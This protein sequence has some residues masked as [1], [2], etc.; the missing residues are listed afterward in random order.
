ML[1]RVKFFLVVLLVVFAM[2]CF[3]FNGAELSKAMNDAAYAGEYLNLIMHP[4]MPKPWTN[5]MYSEMTKKL[6]NAWKVIT[7]EVSSIENE[8][9]IESCRA[10]IE[11]FK[12]SH[13]TYRD[14]GFQV[15]ISLNDRIKF[16]QTHGQL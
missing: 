14:L 4:G 13:G 1:K 10:I 6:G 11:T 15:E 12:M 5:P 9:E 8:K 3:A 16:L 2:P 7:T